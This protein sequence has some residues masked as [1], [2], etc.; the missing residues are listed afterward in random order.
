[1]LGSILDSGEVPTLRH[2]L[3][4]LEI[5]SRMLTEK[6]RWDVHCQIAAD[7]L[8]SKINGTESVTEP[9]KDAYRE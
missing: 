3:C 8:E 7:S 2:E 4:G 6:V 5:A 9:Q 1:M